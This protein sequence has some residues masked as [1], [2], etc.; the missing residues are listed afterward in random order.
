MSGGMIELPLTESIQVKNMFLYFFF[1]IFLLWNLGAFLILQMMHA[2][3][4]VCRIRTFKIKDLSPSYGIN[5]GL[6]SWSRT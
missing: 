1:F 5:F 2:C 6:K 3:K 4:T